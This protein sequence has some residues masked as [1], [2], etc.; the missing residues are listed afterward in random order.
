MNN[1]IDKEAKRL[2]LVRS[3]PALVT[4]ILLIINLVIWH[5][6]TTNTEKACQDYF[7][8]QVRE[9]IINIEN[10]LSKYQQVLFGARGLYDAS[11]S[12]SRAVYHRFVYAQHLEEN[13]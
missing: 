1:I 2:K 11:R 3:P 4:L 5:Q 13:C 8:F 6:T 10:R 7:D 12:V 9:A